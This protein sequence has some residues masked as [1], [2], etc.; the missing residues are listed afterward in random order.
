M[1]IQLLI[2]LSLLISFSSYAKKDFF[3]DKSVTIKELAEK[4]KIAPFKLLNELDDELGIKEIM[5]TS[6]V[7]DIGLTRRQFH[8][9][10]LH[11]YEKPTPLI[12]LGMMLWILLG[13]L[14]LYWLKKKKLNP[15]KRITLF[16]I[17]IVFCGL[18][19]HAKPGAME[20]IVRFFKATT[21]KDSWH[22]KILYFSFF[23]I[24]SLIASNFFCS[25]GCQIRTI[26]DLLFQ[27]FRKKKINYKK[28]PFWI[29]NGIRITLF[30]VFLLFMYDILP[31][32]KT[33]SL[34]HHVN[35]FKIYIWGLG[36]IGIITFFSTII[37]S[38]FIYRPFCSII[39][40]FGLWSWVISHLSFQRIRIDEEKCTKCMSCIK[41]CPN[42]AMDSI[43][44]KDFIKKDCYSC[45]ECI[46]HCLS[47]CIDFK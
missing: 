46:N 20:S 47:N 45:G 39:C 41:A 40:P 28:I 22:N 4:N 36:A 18:I 33:Q 23:S 6:K 13:L 29:T 31:G 42:S 3:F 26:Q 25:I 7:K 32:L 44:N 1:K 5:G 19:L 37:L 35:I 9:L 10:Y 24:F 38:G 27:L 2:T 30:I 12:I 17:S 15:N 11:M 14:T 21:G 34:Y 8:K 16:I 43:F